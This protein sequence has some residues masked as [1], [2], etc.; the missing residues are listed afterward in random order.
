MNDPHAPA[1]Q[2]YLLSALFLLVAPRRKRSSLVSSLSVPNSRSSVFPNRN[3][4]RMFSAMHITVALLQMTACSDPSELLSKGEAFCRRAQAMGADLALFP[5][6]WNALF[7]FPHP[8][9]DL[10]QAPE[11]WQIT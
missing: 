5:E 3:A 8:Q 6:T 10:W 11:L 2:V 9:E 1:W 4:E 7:S